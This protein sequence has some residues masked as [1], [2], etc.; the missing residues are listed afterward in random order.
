MTEQESIEY[1]ARFMGWREIKNWKEDGDIYQWEAYE[2]GGWGIIEDRHWNPL[3][4]WNHWRQ[5]EEK[6]ME[7]QELKNEYISK[8]IEEVECS[9]AGACDYMK[10]EL[11]TRI[12]ALI[13]AH[14]ELYPSQ[15]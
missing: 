11:A 8:L 10:A 12:S 7:D 6:V 5:V 14:K 9:T 2:D 15:K 13:S 3:T 1:L 4:D